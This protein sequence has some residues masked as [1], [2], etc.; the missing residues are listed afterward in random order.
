MHGSAPFTLLRVSYR[1]GP[2][3]LKRYSVKLIIQRKVDFFFCDSTDAPVECRFQ[4]WEYIEILSYL[5]A[6]FKSPPCGDIRRLTH[7]PN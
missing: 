4:N 3:F 6:G 1:I 7:R 5:V 2:S